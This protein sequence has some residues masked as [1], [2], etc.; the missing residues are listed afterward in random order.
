MRR[1]IAKFFIFLAIFLSLENVETQISENMAK[2]EVS[3]TQ[4]TVIVG[5]NHEILLKLV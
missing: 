1:K 3:W 5:E 4:Q 2:F